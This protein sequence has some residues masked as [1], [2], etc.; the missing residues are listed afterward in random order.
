MALT[1]AQLFT[2]IQL[3]T[4]VGVLYITPASPATT[5]IKNLRVRLT[6][7][8][9][10]AV[11]VTLYADAAAA[12]SANANC[13]LFSYSIAA[14]NYVDIDIPTLRAGDTL[15]GFAGTA[16]AVTMHEVGGAIYS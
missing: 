8:H 9:T 12:P 14:N 6:N 11:A 10:N 7:T 2:P 15:R 3:P 16:T 1:I 13:C 5:V 4:S